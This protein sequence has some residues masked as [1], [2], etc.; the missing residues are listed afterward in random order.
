MKLVNLSRFLAAA[1]L[2]P[3]LPQP[4]HAD[5]NVAVERN[6]DGLAFVFK[7][8]PAPAKN[9]AAAQAELTLLDGERDPNGGELAALNDGRVPTEADQPAENFFFRASSEGG[10]LRLDLGR[11]ITVKRVSTY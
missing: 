7:S 8:V 2:A 11:G 4:S 10:R 6:P 5:V 1:V 9:D 3:L